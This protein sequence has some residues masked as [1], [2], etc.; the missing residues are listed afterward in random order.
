MSKY[1]FGEVEKTIGNIV[2]ELVEHCVGW[3]N[4][5]TIG[6]RDHDYFYEKLVE[7]GEI[8]KAYL[9]QVNGTNNK[10]TDNGD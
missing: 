2:G 4:S 10:E 6:L 5:E 1:D 8:A 7:L 3:F 9:E